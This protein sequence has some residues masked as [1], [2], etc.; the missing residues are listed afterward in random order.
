MHRV[1]RS[2][3]GRLPLQVHS[4]DIFWGNKEGE[5]VKG[6]VKKKKKKKKDEKRKK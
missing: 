2:R 6:K 3:C 5:T 1:G 4:R